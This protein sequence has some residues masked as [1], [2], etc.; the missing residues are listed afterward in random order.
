MGSVTSYKSSWPRV[1]LERQKQRH[2]AAGVRLSGTGRGLRHTELQIRLAVAAPH[3]V[4]WVAFPPP[5]NY[6]FYFE[7]LL[8]REFSSR[9]RCPLQLRPPSAWHIHAAA[10]PLPLYP[11]DC[12]L[13]ALPVFYSFCEVFS[14]A[15]WPD[16][17]PN[18]RD[19]TACR[20]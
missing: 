14:P 3:E 20:A 16:P 17:G 15:P 8:P 9:V 2:T 7:T 4:N 5:R 19:R 12:T 1:H 6:V 18:T 13:L 11:I 10:S